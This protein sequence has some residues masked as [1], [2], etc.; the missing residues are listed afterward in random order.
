LLYCLFLFR[1]I[2]I[3]YKNWQFGGGVPPDKSAIPLDTHLLL[4]KY[5]AMH[6]HTKYAFAKKKLEIKPGHI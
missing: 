3:T 6:L 1:E 4:S 2:D 5:F